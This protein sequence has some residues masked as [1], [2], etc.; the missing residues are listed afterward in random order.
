MKSR[1]LACLILWVLAAPLLAQGV[2]VCVQP[3]GTR[4]YRNT[5]DIRGCRRLDTETISTIPAPTANQQAKAGT[6]DS[7]F[8]RIDSQIQR[9]RDQDRLQILMDEV[10]TEES[11]LSE[12]RREYQN[13]EPERLGSERNYAKYQERVAQMKD[14]ILRTEKNIEALKR[15]IGNLK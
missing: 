14:D 7:S 12:L 10:R 13:G 1:L 2:F 9:R 6:L 11:K 5:G 8:P 3:N 4:E 15:E